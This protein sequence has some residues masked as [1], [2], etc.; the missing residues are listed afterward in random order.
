MGLSN[1]YAQ[2]RIDR[3]HQS[4]AQRSVNI[5]IIYE[6]GERYSL[7]G[8]IVLEFDNY[9][10]AV[11]PG[12]ALRSRYDSPAA[13]IQISHSKFQYS[14]N[15]TNVY[16]WGEF[17]FYQFTKPENL[18][19]SPPPH[20]QGATLGNTAWIIARDWSRSDHV[21]KLRGSF[22]GKNKLAVPGVDG[23]KAGGAI[24]DN[25]GLIGIV[26]KDN[27]NQIDYYPAGV[28]RYILVNRLKLDSNK[29]V[30]LFPR[31]HIGA[32]AGVEMTM[33]LHKYDTADDLA[34]LA[35]NTLTAVEYYPND[36]IGMGLKYERTYIS[37]ENGGLSTQDYIS[38]R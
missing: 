6:D 22:I 29:Y 38:F 31:A 26:A 3:L 37:G 1:V 7:F 15:A 32:G 12:E 23:G 21:P 10:F 28:I 17:S 8:L 11:A 27:G 2:S 34:A 35:A 4:M 36:V 13:T 30:R 18:K 25:L 16:P 33:D 19:L 5:D 9:W 20:V 14:L 24:Y